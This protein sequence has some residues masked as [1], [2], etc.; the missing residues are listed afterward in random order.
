MEKMAEPI[1]IP[2]PAEICRQSDRRQIA[3]TDSTHP[4]VH[5]LLLFFGQQQ[6]R[7]LAGYPGTIRLPCRLGSPGNLNIMLG[8]QIEEIFQHIELLHIKHGICASGSPEVL[9][10]YLYPAEIDL[11]H[12]TLVIQSLGDMV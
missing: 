12:D 5:E 10:V 1:L 7:Q 4:S 11:K 9:H 3:R 8:R 6:L 2:Y